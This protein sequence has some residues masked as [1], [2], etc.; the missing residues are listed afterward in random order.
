MGLTP[1]AALDSKSLPSVIGS[2]PLSVLDSQ[3]QLYDSWCPSSTFPFFTPFVVLGWHRCEL[4]GNPEDEV[5]TLG[6][7]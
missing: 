5:G 2:F 4:V 7:P 3:R 1:T 6:L